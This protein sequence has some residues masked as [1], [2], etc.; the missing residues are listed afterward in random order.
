M[1][2]DEKKIRI[3]GPLIFG[4][5]L[6]A[7]FMLPMFA[8]SA[9]HS[10]PLLRMLGSVFIWVVIT[11]EPTRFVILQVYKRL[12][13]RDQTK[14]RIWVT[15]LI[16]FPVTILLGYLRNY[17]EHFL[18]W[19]MPVHN[20]P[21]MLSSIGTS[22]IFVTA[23]AALYEMVFY[24]EKWHQSELEAKELKKMNL[25]MQY[26]SLKVQIQPHFLFNTL[27]TLIGLMKMDVPRAIHFTEEMAYVYRYL[28]EANER[29]LIS[30]AEEMRFTRAY[31][32]MLKTR[33]SEG[34][35]LDALDVEEMEEY[36]LPPLSLQLLLENAVKHNVITK[37]RPLYIK[38]QFHPDLQCVVLSNNLQKKQ[39]QFNTGLGLVQLQKKFELLHLPEVIIEATADDFTV[40]L[41]LLKVHTYENSHH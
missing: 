13:S 9:S 32:F 30:L 26:D 40:T 7:F 23:E 33:Y 1:L 25:Q 12:G 17:L 34:L 11:W 14:K 2:F 36:S 35:H 10:Y 24:I 5:I 4:T 8:T 19:E 41:P 28:L 38:I 39:R 37:D 27:N 16:L 6:M 22:V 3:Y 29:Q 18:I 15:G 31:F 21:F 20:I